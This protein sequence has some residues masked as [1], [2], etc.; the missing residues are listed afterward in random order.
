MTQIRRQTMTSD[1]NA[2][3]AATAGDTELALWIVERMR[4][5]E[6]FLGIIRAER[7]AGNRDVLDTA[8]YIARHRARLRKLFQSDTDDETPLPPQT[9]AKM[10]A[11]MKRDLLSSPEEVIEKALDAYLQL[12]PR[13][14]DGIAADRQSV[15]DAARD[16]IMR[17]TSVEFAPGFTARLASA[18]RDEI[19]RM[20]E[21]AIGRSQDL[22]R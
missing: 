22:E 2:V 14:L 20:S 6:R 4:D 9:A 11:I 10:A 3:P 17:G 19:A 21:R 18:A 7:R 12:H 16:E 8:E 15:F 13:G 5:S 1:R